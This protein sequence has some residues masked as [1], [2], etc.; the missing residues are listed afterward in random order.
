M[1]E[2]KK[3]GQILNQEGRIDIKA[4]VRDFIL[5]QYRDGEEISA[6]WIEEDLKRS[7]SSFPIEGV[8]FRYAK[9]GEIYPKASKRIAKVAEEVLIEIF[10]ET[11]NEPRMLVEENG[12]FCWQTR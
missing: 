12:A 7:E 1:Y 11:E 6:R 3:F 5:S 2:I 8:R 10:C 4:V 9:F